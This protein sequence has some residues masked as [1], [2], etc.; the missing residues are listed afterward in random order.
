M[1]CTF[2]G[3]ARHN[4]DGLYCRSCG[5]LDPANQSDV[6][7]E[8]GLPAIAASPAV[9]VL[10][11][12]PQRD[13]PLPSPPALRFSYVPWT[14]GSCGVINMPGS[15][16]CE[17]GEGYRPGMEQQPFVAKN[18]I[19]PN[20]AKQVAKT[21]WYEHPVV[22]CLFFGV[23]MRIFGIWGGASGWIVYEWQRRY[24]G[25]WQAAGLG[26][27][28]AFAVWMIISALIPRTDFK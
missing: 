26:V 11:S 1:F 7:T 10:A 18:K 8:T 21:S 6:I 20:R 13:A 2:C 28:A 16:T 12:S 4:N 15:S 25:H 24:R 23:S 17:C 14:C 22:M 19:E 5:K 3:K 9:S 27:I